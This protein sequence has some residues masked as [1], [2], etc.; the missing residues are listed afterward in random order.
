MVVQQ[1]RRRGRDWRR[2]EER[3]GF[4]CDSLVDAGVALH[5]RHQSLLLR[6]FRRGRASPL[7]PVH[8]LLP[9][10]GVGLPPDRRLPPSEA[11][12][13]QTAA[14]QGA[15]QVEADASQQL[16]PAPVSLGI[17]SSTRRL[18]GQDHPAKPRLAHGGNSVPLGNQRQSSK[19]FVLNNDPAI[20]IV[21]HLTY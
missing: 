17:C 15:T 19:R 21:R 13:T 5:P 20:R 18:L 14:A 9:P 3:S 6:G 8:G 2:P 10:G 4:D 16:S 1:F 11:S 7:H 12:A